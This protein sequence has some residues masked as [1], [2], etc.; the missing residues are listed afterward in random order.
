MEHPV[1]LFRLPGPQ[2][3]GDPGWQGRAQREAVHAAA[4]SLR[5]GAGVRGGL[6]HH[7][8]QVDAP[9]HAPALMS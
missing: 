4:G 5:G 6:L 7:H 9:W 8:C 2:H 3:H 1:L